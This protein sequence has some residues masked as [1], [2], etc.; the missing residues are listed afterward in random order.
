MDLMDD[1]PKE[2]DLIRYHGHTRPLRK[3]EADRIREL[4]LKLRLNE[5]SRMRRPGSGTGQ[6]AR[7]ARRP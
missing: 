2:G 6:S 4:V 7:S 1:E 5:P 3:A